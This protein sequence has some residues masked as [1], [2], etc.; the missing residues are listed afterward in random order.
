MKVPFT[1]LQVRMSSLPVGKLELS[2]FEKIFGIPLE[3]QNNMVTL[4]GWLT[5]QMGGIPK[6]G[7]KFQT[8]EFLFQ[9]LAADP[10]RVRRIYVRKLL[11]TQ[12]K[13]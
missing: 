8:A 6:S 2:D 13:R 10:N 12:E 1:P 4:G 3:S 9:V 5:E 7:T 11:I